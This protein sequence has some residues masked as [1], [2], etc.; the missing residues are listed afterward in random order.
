[1]QVAR[2]QKQRLRISLR[3]NGT[4]RIQ[5]EMM[6]QMMLMCSRRQWKTVLLMALP[7]L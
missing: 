6:T 5:K 2:M 3:R 4:V 7:L 1:M